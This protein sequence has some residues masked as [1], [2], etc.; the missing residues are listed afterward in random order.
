MAVNI[1]G[2]TR[3]N[4]EFSLFVL[5]QPFLVY[6]NFEEKKIIRIVFNVE[7]LETFLT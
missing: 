6:C 7:G 3:W 1:K 2:E 5:D 4:D